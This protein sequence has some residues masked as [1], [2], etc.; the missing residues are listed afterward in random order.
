MQLLHLYL[1]PGH[2]YFG[3]HGQAPGNHPMLEVQAAQCI[4]GAGIRGDRFYNYKDNYK[5]QITFFEDEVYQSLCQEF[6][7]WDK[8]ASVFRRNVLVRGGRLSE[9]IGQ[10]FQIQ[11]IRFFGVEECKPCY[12]MDHAFCPGAEQALKGRGGLR[13][14]ILT[15]GVLQVRRETQSVD[16]LFR[17]YTSPQ[18]A[19]A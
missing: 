19:A 18:L 13:A 14:Q 11:D 10:E 7:V 2:N 3:H 1:S 9:L 12:W 15:S 4:S 8:A 6:G 5:G 17:V 16:D